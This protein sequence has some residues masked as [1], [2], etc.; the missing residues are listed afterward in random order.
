MLSPSYLYLAIFD[1]SP[2]LD[3]QAV[4]G[5]LDNSSLRVVTVHVYPVITET[6]L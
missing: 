2:W 3:W 4:L 5:S 1:L 6:S